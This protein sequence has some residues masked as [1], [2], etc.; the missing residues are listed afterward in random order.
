M[1]KRSETR[2][3]RYDRVAQSLSKSVW[4]AHDLGQVIGGL[5]DILDYRNS[6]GGIAIE[7]LFIAVTF[8]VKIELPDQVPNVMKSRIHSLAPKWTMNVSGIPSYEDPSDAQL[9]RVSVMNA[10]VATPVKRASLDPTASPLNENLPYDVE[11]GSFA[12][13]APKPYSKRGAL[14][15]CVGISSGNQALTRCASMLL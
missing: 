8:Q 9:P 15:Y 11:R 13:R 14:L 2:H 1:L 4:G 5:N 3:H 12:F 6:L 10:K 7:Q